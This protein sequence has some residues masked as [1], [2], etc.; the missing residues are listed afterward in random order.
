MKRKIQGLIGFLKLIRYDIAGTIGLAAILF[1]VAIAILAPI[2][3][4]HDP[5][6][7]N[8]KE[9]CLPPS[10]A[11]PFGTDE[12]GRDLLSRIIWGS[13]IS[14][15]VSVASVAIG[16]TV[17]VVIGLAAGYLGGITDEIIMRLT[18]VWLSLPYFLLA[19]VIVSA[20]GPGLF[21]SLLAI[22]LALVPSYIRLVRGT[23]MSVKEEDYVKAAYVL[24]NNS[25][26]RLFLHI[27][28][29]ILAP[30][31]VLATLNIAGSILSLAALGFIGLGAQPPTPEWGSII[32]ASRAYIIVSPHLFIFPG[33]VI[34]VTVLG[35]NL[36]GD[37][38]RDILDPRLRT[39]IK[40]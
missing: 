5:L 38:M 15:G 23:T 37:A 34:L 11:H 2:I 20:L 40:R 14:L 24:G 33:I 29:N 25:W 4:M 31:I 18:D 3:G 19:I 16:A 30:I 17:G 10:L 36:L 13:R 32:S 39:Q 1:T 12:F 9:A 35:F 6:D 22:A 21:N 27:L 7:Q 8:L 28:P 26:R